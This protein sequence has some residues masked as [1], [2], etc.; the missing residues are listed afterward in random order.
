MA[1]DGRGY[2][3]IECCW[4]GVQDAAWWVDEERE[5]FGHGPYVTESR[6]VWEWPG[7]SCLKRGDR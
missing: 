5:V 1:V 6:R 3:G 2:V 4:C 7:G